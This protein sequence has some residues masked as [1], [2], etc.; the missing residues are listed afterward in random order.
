MEEPN[1]SFPLFLLC[2]FDLTDLRFS[3]LSLPNNSEENPYGEQ[4]EGLTDDDTRMQRTAMEARA[5]VEGFGRP[6][7]QS[8]FATRLSALEF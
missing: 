6:V 1:S 8:E 2:A 7:G 5:S 4:Q 3:F